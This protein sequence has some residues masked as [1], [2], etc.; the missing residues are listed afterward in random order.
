M[1]RKELKGSEYITRLFLPV[2]SRS[3]N[4]QR[5]EQPLVPLFKFWV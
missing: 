5:T 1:E 3:E 2:N 4:N